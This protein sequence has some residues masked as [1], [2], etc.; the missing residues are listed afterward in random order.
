MRLQQLTTIKVNPD[1]VIVDL[2]DANLSDY[3]FL[4]MIE[5][6]ALS[7]SE[8]EVNLVRT[9]ND[10]YRQRVILL[11]DRELDP[12]H[13]YERTGA[14]YVRYGGTPEDLASTTARMYFS[15]GSVDSSIVTQRA[16]RA[17]PSK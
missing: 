5:P 9:L 7:F 11:T 3:P 12:Y 14:E 16:T 10:E 2:T 13:I 6:G 4:Y 15:G 8:D 1:P 17:P